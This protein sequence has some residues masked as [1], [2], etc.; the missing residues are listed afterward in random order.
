MQGSRLTAFELHHDGIDV[1]LIPDTAVAYTMSST[2][3]RYV[4]VGSR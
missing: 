2:E 4:I 3:I 1:S